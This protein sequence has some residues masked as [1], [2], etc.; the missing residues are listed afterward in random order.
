MNR[1]P[2]FD[3]AVFL[4][5][6][7]DRCI[8]LWPDGDSDRLHIWP[9]SQLTAEEMG[10]LRTNKAAVLAYLR[11]RNDDL[12]PPNELCDAWRRR[13]TNTSDGSRTR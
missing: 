7:R 5:G 4:A 10:F 8:S 13:Y 11:K 9:A 1:P 12:L 6:L 3:L 2:T